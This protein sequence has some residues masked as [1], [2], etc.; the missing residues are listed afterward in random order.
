[1][2]KKVLLSLT[3]AIEFILFYFG[4]FYYLNYIDTFKNAGLAAVAGS[5]V[6]M[7]LIYAA[8]VIIR[9]IGSI[10][11]FVPRWT[12]RLLFIIAFPFGATTA[13]EGLS[14]MAMF[15]ISFSI[16]VLDSFTG[17]L[18]AAIIKRKLNNGEVIATT[19]LSPLIGIL[20][21]TLTINILSNFVDFRGSFYF[22]N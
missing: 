16:V 8:F 9:L 7:A 15:G 21:F 5:A 3:F 11:K 20:L 1:M 10:N 18:I 14:L 22:L 12:L 4:V 19:L 13:M 17:W 2:R 6:I